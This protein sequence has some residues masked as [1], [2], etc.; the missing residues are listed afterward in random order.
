MYLYEYSRS[1]YALSR[2][3]TIIE[4]YRRT[5]GVIDRV[6]ASKTIDMVVSAPVRGSFGLEIL[7]PAVGQ[8]AG[9]IVQV[10]FKELFAFVWAKL[11]PPDEGRDKMS[12]ELAKV[13]LARDR[14]RTRRAEIREGGETDRLRIFA[15]VVKNQSA[16]TLQA[17]ELVDRA[18][19]N[20]DPRTLRAGYDPE[21]LIREREMLAAD[22]IRERLLGT[23]E[24]AFESSDPRSINRLASKVRPMVEEIGLPLRNSAERCVIGDADNDDAFIRLDE[25]RLRA[26]NTRDIDDNEFEVRCIIRSYDKFTGRG[27]VESDDFEKTMFFMVETELK[28]ALRNK[29]ISAMRQN[30]VRCQFAAYRDA[31]DVIT[32]LILRDVDIDD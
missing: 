29:I 18:L 14:E 11:L 19:Q 16:T 6:T 7:V 3:I 20:G 10:S 5:G 32:S 30:Y 4:Q 31:S 23:A 17:L 15:D 25:D 1:Q 9:D 2:F 12:V 8:V 28:K 22:V 26:V 21:K 24:K 27:K 13:E